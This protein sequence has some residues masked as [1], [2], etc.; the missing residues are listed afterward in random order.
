MSFQ[1]GSVGIAVVCGTKDL[2]FQSWHGQNFVYQWYNRKDDNKEKEGGNGP[3]LKNI[4]PK[5]K[6]YRRSLA[7]PPFFTSQQQV[8]TTS[9]SLIDGQQGSTET[10]FSTG[11]SFSWEKKSFS[12]V[13]GNSPKVPLGKLRWLGWFKWEIYFPNWDEVA[14]VEVIWAWAFQAWAKP[15]LYKLSSRW[16][17]LYTYNLWALLEPCRVFIVSIFSKNFSEAVR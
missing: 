15:E 4:G 7:G 10:S 1:R 16:A 2:Q 3:S 5:L 9:D 12:P 13:P 14:W 17:E 8:L 11:S 6:R